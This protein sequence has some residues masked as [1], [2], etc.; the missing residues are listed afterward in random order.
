MK[1]V[2]VATSAEHAELDEDGP[3]LRAA[4]R[5]AATAAE[6]EPFGVRT[7]AWDDVDADWDVPDV[8]LI[9]STWDYTRRPTQFLGWARERRCL[10]NPV[11]VLAWNTDKHYLA[12]L[13]EAGVPVVP[14]VFLEPGRT[15]STALATAAEAVGGAVGAPASRVVV[16]PTISAGSAD[17]AIIDA[18]DPVGTTLI[19]R[20]LGAGRSV[21][22]QP[23]QASVADRGETALVY[24]AGSFSHAVRKEVAV[25]VGRVVEQGDYAAETLHATTATPAELAVADAAMTSVPDLGELAYAR[26]DVVHGPGGPEDPLVLEVELTEPSLFLDHAPRARLSDFAAMVIGHLDR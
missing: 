22:V 19:D 21:M 13:A 14:T 3:L 17:T 15:S 25:P 6:V 2:W 9:R 7:V 23:F 12:E 10:V 18:D 26:V 1:Q 24:L 11:D 4:L 20:L 16:K 5:A 8:V